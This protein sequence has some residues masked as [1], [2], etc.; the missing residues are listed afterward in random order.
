MNDLRDHVVT[1]FKYRREHVRDGEL[2]R[3]D[4]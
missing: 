4:N 2:I 1:I 3:Y